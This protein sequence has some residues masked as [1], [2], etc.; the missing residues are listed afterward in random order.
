MKWAC[1][2]APF[3]KFVERLLQIGLDTERGKTGF[4]VFIILPLV[5]ISKVFMP[6]DLAKL[7][8]LFFA[9]FPPDQNTLP[10]DLAALV[11]LN[12]NLAEAAE[13]AL[14]K[15]TTSATFS[16]TNPAP[17]EGILLATFAIP[18]TV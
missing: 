11:K 1:L 8:A 2:L 14:F 5:V 18:K 16:T 10:L 15:I 7:A 4:N 17:Y 3:A 9:A 13:L 12:P 6:L